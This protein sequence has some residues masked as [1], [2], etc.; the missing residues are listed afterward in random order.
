MIDRLL[1]A[2]ALA[3]VLTAGR[4]DAAPTLPPGSLLRGPGFVLKPPALLGGPGDEG[5][6]HDVYI[7]PQRPGQNRVPYWQHDWRIF[8]FDT[9]R[10]GGGVR[11]YFYDREKEAAS[12]AA[13][14]LEA[15]YV[16]LTDTFHYLPRSTIPFVLYASYPE[17]LATN[18]FFIEE[19]T[20]GVTD[21]RDLR[22]SVP[23][24]GDVHYF[25]RVATH[26]MVHQVTI[27][28]I[29]DAALG[30]R[31]DPPLGQIPLW[32]IEGI[33]EWGTFDGMDPEGDFII[34]DLITNPDPEKGYQLPDLFDDRA[35]GYI[36]VYKL[37]QARLT[38]L[39]ETYGREKI[40]ELLE[41]VGLLGGA[42]AEA[43][44]ERGEAV[45]PPRPKPEDEHRPPPDEKRT[46]EANSPPDDRGL[47]PDAHPAGTK[48]RP[49]RIRTFEDYVSFVVDEPPQKLRERYREWLKRRY[50][51]DWLHAQQ[52]VSDFVQYQALA[53][54]P[55]SIST[56][57]DGHLLLYRT[58]ERMTGSSALYLQ[59]ARDPS[60]RVVVARDQRPGVESL[61]PVD[62][63]VTSLRANTLVF[64]ARSK[65]NDHLYVQTLRRTER[66]HKGELKV[67]LEL[68]PQR[69]I[70]LGEVMEV[71]DPA[72][73]P[74]ARAV[75]F[76]GVAPDGFR[77]LYVVPLEGPNAGKLQR[78]TNDV[79]SESDVAWDRDRLL[80][81]SDHTESHKRNVFEFDLEKRVARRLTFHE[82]EDRDPVPALGG[83]VYRSLRSGKPDLWL[84]K[85]G[86]ERR[87]TD[88]AAAMLT[89]VPTTDDAL[90]AIA[91]YSGA[92]RLLRIPKTAYLHE[93]PEQAP[94]VGG[95]GYVAAVEMGRVEYP[96]LPIPGD[97]P[98]YDPRK[99]SNWRFEG[100]AGALV[101]PVAVGAAGVA[102]TDLMR[103][104]AVLINLAI[105]G[106]FKLTDASVFYLNQSRRPALGVGA[107]HT[108]EPRRDKTFAGVE[109]FY[110]Q[111]A[112]GVAGL[113]SYPFDRFRRLEGSL[114]VRGI[115]R[116]AFT[117]YTG[118]LD[119]DW[120]RLNGGIEPEVVVSGQYGYDTTRLHAQAGPVAGSSLL[121]SVT[122]GYLPV[123]QFGYARFMADAQ[124]RIALFGR[125]HLMLRASAGTSTSGRFAPQFFLYSVDN[126][127]GYRFGDSRLLG[128][129]YYATNVR[130]TVPV[131]WLVQVP[132]LSGIYVTGGFDFGAAF[133]EWRDLWAERSLSGVL[134]A[135]LALGGLLFQLHWGR[136][137]GIGSRNGPE[138]W[139]FNLNI[140]YLYY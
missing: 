110:F 49:R 118:A 36:G 27:Q 98:R 12:Y 100:T 68:G 11:L 132:L 74:D 95:S 101:G 3:V 105:Y 81:V 61:H 73:S 93:Q 30:A 77:D 79:W 43:R 21:P 90:Y 134:G 133:T 82:D 117:D 52:R 15:S 131:D 123:R 60:S 7:T 124:H 76:A 99:S 56:S 70:D 48:A 78:V 103:D 59:D 2:G 104:H 113:V 39:A 126:L 58:V 38:F 89:A 112:F 115:E 96:Q 65:D 129:H 139:V 19:G 125:T 55:D 135:D 92:H 6:L 122:A 62:R 130:L 33:A 50:F 71:Y 51:R 128:D 83:I 120:R 41:R 66:V 91:F 108:F 64:A 25:T 53:G 88:T 116:F 24:F 9:E 140:K 32:F 107:F 137:I 23:F 13:A 119:A 57:E 35:G 138:P 20:L 86:V 37:G 87:L 69:E 106:S 102:I 4:A 5:P 26:E 97:T 42:A 80:Y 111:R 75:A 114:E 40:V 17:F 127:E 121:G 63:R 14:S 136:L 84:L 18:L 67:R 47:P 10:G 109:N 31:V 28:K 72:L 8:E 54:E 45:P 1:L 29:R 16:R 34:R 94:G 85:D 46:E 22:M 44:R